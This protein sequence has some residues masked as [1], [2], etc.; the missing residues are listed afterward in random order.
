[1]TTQKSSKISTQRRIRSRSA[2]LVGSALI[3]TL[4]LRILHFPVSFLAKVECTLVEMC[5]IGMRDFCRQKRRLALIQCPI[6]VASSL[7]ELGPLPV[8]IGVGSSISICD[9]D[10]SSKVTVKA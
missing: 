6:A 8:P 1:M 10:S 3:L 2:S 4:R 5:F 7:E 9:K